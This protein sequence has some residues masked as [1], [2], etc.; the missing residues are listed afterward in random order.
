MNRLLPLLLACLAAGPA[1]AFAPPAGASSQ[2]GSRPA[3]DDDNDVVN[4]LS[5]V[6]AVLIGYL[7]TIL[8]P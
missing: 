1:A 3:G 6:F 5:G 4:F 8:V 7:L 2:P